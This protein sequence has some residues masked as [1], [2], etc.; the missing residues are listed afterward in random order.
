M[1]FSCK[2][3]YGNGQRLEWFQKESLSYAHEAHREVCRMFCILS[4]NGNDTHL[5]SILEYT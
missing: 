1:M 4:M 3:I 5:D 2:L